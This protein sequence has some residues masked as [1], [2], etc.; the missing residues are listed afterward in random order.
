M[1]H[2]GACWQEWNRKYTHTSTL[3]YFY[4]VVCEKSTFER[5]KNMAMRT[6]ILCRAVCVCDMNKAGMC[7]TSANFV[8][9]QPFFAVHLYR[10]N[11]HGCAPGSSNWKQLKSIS[12]AQLLIKQI[13]TNRE[14]DMFANCILIFRPVCVCLGSV[15]SF[16]FLVAFQSVKCQ[17]TLLCN[18]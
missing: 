9:N 15:L 6:V 8:M 1:K 10:V 2:R 14:T 13:K 5:C 7:S 18:C 4:S 12:G 16:Y 11:Q 3:F 17:K